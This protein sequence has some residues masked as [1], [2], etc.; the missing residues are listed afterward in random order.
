MI[1][2]L[3]VIL[4]VASNEISAGQGFTARPVMTL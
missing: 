2:Y 4:E 3:K 1:H